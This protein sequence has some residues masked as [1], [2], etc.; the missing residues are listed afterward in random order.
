MGQPLK[1]GHPWRE[2]GQWHKHGWKW[3][4]RAHDEKNIL[5]IIC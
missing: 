1:S 5:Q 2:V 4:M 3:W